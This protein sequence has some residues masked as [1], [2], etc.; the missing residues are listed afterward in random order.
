MEPC[1]ILPFFHPTR[2]VF[3]DDDRSFLSLFPMRLGARFPYSSYDSP[4][5]FL[6]DLASGRIHASIALDWWTCYSGLQ[7]HPPLEQVIG[8]DKSMIFQHLFDEKRFGVVSVVVVDYEMPEMSGISLCREIA[9][10]PCRKI[11][12]TGQ[13]DKSLAIHAFNEG[14]IDL[15][16][17]KLHPRLEAE[18]NHAIRRFQLEY[19][20]KATEIVAT[21]L[22]TEDPP[23][24]S[25]QAFCRLFH[26][27]C[28]DRG[29]VEYY[30][31]DDPKGFLLVDRDANG[32][33]LLIFDSGEL[34]A[35]CA[36]ASLS[37]APEGVMVQ[38]QSRRSVL[39]FP[40]DEGGR[41]LHE[42]QWWDACVPLRAFPGRRDRFY[43]LIDRPEPY[44][45]SPDTVLGLGR[46]LQA[47]D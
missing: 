35:Q 30:T 45:A 29:I 24:W 47:A 17:P 4:F 16:L 25:D 32:Q 36:A 21:V 34:D 38:L 19:L 9:D 23:L 40:H 42:Q 33:L 1:S 26:Q 10:L 6:D 37:R 14:L 22:R 18:L 41:V 2:V 13:A 3:I 12:L 8:L 44:P 5:E 7:G 20:A 43:A 28:T 39:H 46:Y 31:V 11:L 15:Y 27:I